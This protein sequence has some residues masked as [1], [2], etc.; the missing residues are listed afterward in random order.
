M[1]SGLDN[2]VKQINE[3]IQATEG[4]DEKSAQRQKVSTCFPTVNEESLKTQSLRHHL[5]DMIME[6]VLV[7]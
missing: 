2:F 3:T 4:F 6:C 5:S 1:T 7:Y